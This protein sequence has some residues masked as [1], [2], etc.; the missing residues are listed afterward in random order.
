MDLEQHGI[1]WRKTHDLNLMHHE[2]LGGADCKW[3]DEKATKWSL[4]IMAV[5]WRKFPSSSSRFLSVRRWS[6]ACQAS[7]RWSFSKAMKSGI[8]IA[9]AYLVGKHLKKNCICNTCKQQIW[10]VAVW[11]WTTKSQ[12]IRVHILCLR[13]KPYSSSFRFG[14]FQVNFPHQFDA[15]DFLEKVLDHLECLKMFDILHDLMWSFATAG[16]SLEQSSWRL[17][18]LHVRPWEMARCYAKK[19]K[20]SWATSVTRHLDQNAWKTLGIWFSICGYKSA[21][22]WLFWEWLQRWEMKGVFDCNSW[23]LIVQGLL[24]Q[25]ISEVDTWLVRLCWFI[26][27]SRVKT[28]NSILTLLLFYQM[29][30]NGTLKSV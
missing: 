16:A 21:H 26:H 25:N 20:I 19:W 7:D 27:V 8:M 13:S 12:V 15:N 2:M 29:W 17:K 30:V 24:T 23:S 22:H 28:T 11:V 10:I 3:W 4:I 9:E 1:F 5:C 18:W 6:L 14:Q